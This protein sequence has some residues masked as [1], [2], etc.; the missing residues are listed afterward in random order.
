MMM[1]TMIIIVLFVIKVEICWHFSTE[2]TRTPF[3]D[4][5]KGT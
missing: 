5:L 1:V 2:G 3:R 4:W